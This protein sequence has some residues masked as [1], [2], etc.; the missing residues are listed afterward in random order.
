M[1]HGPPAPP[2][3]ILHVGCY[4][5][6]GYENDQRIRNIP[7]RWEPILEGGAGGQYVGQSTMTTQEKFWITENQAIFKTVNLC[8]P[9]II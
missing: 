9:K 6:W 3:R 4:K 8:E 5:D 7:H 1:P 2:S